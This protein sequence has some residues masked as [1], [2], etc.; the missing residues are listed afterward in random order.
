VPAND[1]KKADLIIDDRSSINLITNLDTQWQLITDQVMGGISEGRLTLDSYKGKKALHLQ[2]DVSTENNGGF[3]QMAVNLTN[4]KYLDAS[5]YAGIELEVAGNNES[6]NIH[7]R[8][9][10]LW[11]PWQSYRASFKA[12]THWH[13]IRIPF[14]DLTTYKTTQKFRQDRLKRIG[15]LGI[16]RAFEAD[17]YLASMKLYAVN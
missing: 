2:G 8:T 11:L 14:I 5:A 3:V 10:G 17:L 6:Y 7:L 4:D 16:G 9:A 13:T 1:L 15:L 12:T